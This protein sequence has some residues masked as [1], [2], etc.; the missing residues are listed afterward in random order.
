MTD[1]RGPQ[2]LWALEHPPVLDSLA[3]TRRVKPHRGEAGFARALLE[4]AIRNADLK[5]GNAKP[6]REYCLAHG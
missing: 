3:K 6:E 4:D 5:Q 2:L 1:D